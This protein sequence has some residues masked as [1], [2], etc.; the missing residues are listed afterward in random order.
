M[1][2]HHLDLNPYQN[3]E[4]PDIV[5]PLP[6]EALKNKNIL[7]ASNSPRRRELL[8]LIV[9]S[10]QI[11]QSRDINEV[12]P[13]DLPPEKVP[14]YLSKLKADA[15]NDLLKSDELIITADTVVI[16]DDKI[17]GK[18][19]D[20][21]EAIAM[22]K[23]LQS[24]THTVVTGVTLRS[25]EG[26][27]SDTFAVKTQVTFGALTDN[28]I[29]EYVERY[30]PLDKAGSYGIQE[31]LGAAAIVGINGCF[32]NVMGLPLHELYTHLKSFF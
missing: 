17:L 16:L 19:K 13:S 8:G 21:R 14:E 15:Y 29:E 11:A 23:A 4:L 6:C 18:P 1:T 26:K 3:D 24:N 22:L 28:E 25:L 2:T 32:Y 20:D 5:P 31:W 9:P 10:F 27:K 30:S 12:Y 7:L